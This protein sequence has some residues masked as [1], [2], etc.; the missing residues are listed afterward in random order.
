MVR[1][2]ALQA[3]GRRFESCTAH[4]VFPL[5]SGGY[6][7]AAN[8]TRCFRRYEALC[9]ARLIKL[10]NRIVA[11]LGFVLRPG[12]LWFFCSF[13]SLACTCRRTYSLRVG[14]AGGV[15]GVHLGS[16]RA[17]IQLELADECLELKGETGEVRAGFRCRPPAWP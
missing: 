3:G 9:N 2:P 5:Y 8:C 4:Q 6:L 7:P 13:L 10:Q 15:S 12:L 16:V 11:P 1:A 17:R 14:W